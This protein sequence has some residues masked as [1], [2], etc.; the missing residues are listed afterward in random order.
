MVDNEGKEVEMS[1]KVIT[2]RRREKGG[3]KEWQ[4]DGRVQRREYMEVKAIIRKKRAIKEKRERESNKTRK[5]MAENE[6]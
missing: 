5:K 2:E 3:K 6:R 4:T 1:E